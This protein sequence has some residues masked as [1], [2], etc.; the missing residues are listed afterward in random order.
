MKLESNLFD[1]SESDITMS[2]MMYND[3]I[4][5]C[6]IAPYHNQRS[7]EMDY[8]PNI[9]MFPEKEMSQ[10]QTRQF[11][12][13]I[14]NSDFEE[15]LIITAEIN[16]IYDM[17]DSSV[18]ILTEFDTIVPSTEKT[19]AANQHTIIHS[20]LNN[21]SHQKSEAEKIK[22]HS[23]IN[24]IIEILNDGNDITQEEYDRIMTFIGTIGEE[25]ISDRLKQMLNCKTIKR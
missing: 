23:E 5:K 10:N 13:M 16:I 14:V 6:L 25:I 3:K 12:S 24:K 1:M 17:I 8:A 7:I 4:V 22:S 20:I 18:R 15:V 19:F 21:E 9:F 2:K 11:I